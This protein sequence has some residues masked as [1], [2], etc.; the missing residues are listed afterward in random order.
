MKKKIHPE[1]KETTITCICGNVFHTRSTG[2]DMKTNTCSACHPFYTGTTKY[3]DSAGRIEQFRKRYGK[4][5]SVPVLP[6]E[7]SSQK[8]AKPHKSP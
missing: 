1:Y 4:K 8:I 7:A 2:K 3:M 6:S 5:S